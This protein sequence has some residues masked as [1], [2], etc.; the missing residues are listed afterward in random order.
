MIC[1]L[2]S[3]IMIHLRSNALE[4]FIYFWLWW[5]SPSGLPPA[6]WCWIVICIHTWHYS[7]DTKMTIMFSLRSSKSH[8]PSYLSTT[9]TVTLCLFR[10]SKWVTNHK[11]LP[12]IEYAALKEIN[13]IVK[14]TMVLKRILWSLSTQFSNNLLHAKWNQI[15]IHSHPPVISFP[16][17]PCFHV[18]TQ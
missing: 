11:T 13:Y 4:G 16:Y 3:D 9:L 6:T 17:I 12:S 7:H 2:Y 15:D 8:H 1:V 14:S 5:V 10:M 18:E